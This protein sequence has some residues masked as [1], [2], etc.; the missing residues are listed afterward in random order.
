MSLR[1]SIVSLLAA[2]S[3]MLSTIAGVGAQKHSETGTV[4]IIDE[5]VFFVQI[6]NAVEF[7]DVTV[8]ANTPSGAASATVYIAYLDTQAYRP[9]FRTYLRSS[10]FVSGSNTIAA[11]NLKPTT[12]YNPGQGQ[13]DA[14]AGFNVG[15]IGGY[16]GSERVTR[17]SKPW[18]GG[19][20]ATPQ[21]V[22]FGYNGV[23]TIQ[24]VAPIDLQLSVPAGSVP[25]EYEAELTVE[26]TL[27]IQP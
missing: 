13:W 1:K 26:V 20:L 6:A 16:N 14:V 25:G 24:T 9:A 5:G 22:G 18:V 23:G 12:I 2:G 15:D 17:D 27:G 21:Y 7:S 11:S 19:S 3:I 4:E 10:D 8:N